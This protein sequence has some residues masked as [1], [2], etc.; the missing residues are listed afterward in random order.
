MFNVQ[1][2]RFSD[3]QLIEVKGLTDPINI[4][5]RRKFGVKSDNDTCFFWSETDSAWQT[6]GVN[7]DT[8][9]N[10]NIVCKTTHLTAFGAGRK[11]F[12]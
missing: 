10:E 5:L 2:C 4:N 1:I 11:K 7:I 6:D 8:S 3:F 9:T 12:I